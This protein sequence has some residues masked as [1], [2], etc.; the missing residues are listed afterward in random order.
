MSGSWRTAWQAQDIVV[1]RNDAEVDRVRSAEIARVVLVHRGEPLQ[2]PAVFIH[3]Q[4]HAF[5]EQPA[6]L[7][8]MRKERIQ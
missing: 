6:F 8:S 3:V 2:V 5:R 4:A 1:Y 7:V